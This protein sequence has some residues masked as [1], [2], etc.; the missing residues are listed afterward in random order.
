MIAVAV[1]CFV[2]TRPSIW[3]QWFDADLKSK[4]VRR[5]ILKRRPDMEAVRKNGGRFPILL[6]GALFCGLGVLAVG[7]VILRLLGVR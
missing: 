7:S 6:I 1:Y 3:D 2:I 5:A 4:P